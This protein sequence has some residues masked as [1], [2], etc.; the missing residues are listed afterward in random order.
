MGC[1]VQ[2]P[3]AFAAGANLGRSGT[4]LAIIFVSA[5]SGALVSPALIGFAADHFGLRAAMGIPL[6][7]AFVVIA[8]ARNLSPRTGLAPTPLPA[9]R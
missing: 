1:A 5:Y 6:V 2:L 7:A 3:L 8:L 9:G 4:S